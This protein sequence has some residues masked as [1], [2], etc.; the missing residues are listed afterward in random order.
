MVMKKKEKNVPLMRDA[1]TCRICGTNADRYDNYF[2]C[3]NNPSHLA[4]LLTGTFDEMKEK[5]GKPMEE[6]GEMSDVDNKH[7]YKCNV[8]LDM[9]GV[10]VDFVTSALNVHI[11]RI[12]EEGRRHLHWPTGEYD[13]PKVPNIS[14]EEFWEKIEETSHFWLNL[15]PYPWHK[16]LI[17]AVKR[18]ARGTVLFCSSPTTHAPS[19][20]TG[21]VEWLQRVY[22]DGDSDPCVGHEE[23]IKNF[24]LTSQKWALASPSTVLIDDS[25]KNCKEFRNAGGAAILFPRHW[26]SNHF[27]QAYPACVEYTLKALQELCGEEMIM[28]RAYEL[29]KRFGVIEIEEV[30]EESA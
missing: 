19:S 6:A 9:D 25:D 23:R 8:L 18:I 15:Q 1:I 4:D 17:D 21:K 10:I 26:N 2:Q 3:Q 11:N 27:I 16:T 22:G 12:G 7:K 13:I 28:M 20:A 30:E 29:A 5:K 14:I 24:I